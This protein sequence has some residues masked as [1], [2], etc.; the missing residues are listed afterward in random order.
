MPGDSFRDEC[1]CIEYS[2]SV[3]AQCLH[4]DRHTLS[5]TQ[6][7]YQDLSLV[8]PRR[9]VFPYVLAAVSWLLH[10]RLDVYY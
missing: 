6:C 8:N 3:S 5:H 1:V 7:P 2:Y 9:V 10:A 4:I